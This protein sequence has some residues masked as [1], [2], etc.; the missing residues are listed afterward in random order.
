MLRSKAQGFRSIRG[1]NPKWTSTKVESLSSPIL[2]LHI[3]AQ[4]VHT[5]AKMC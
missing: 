2:A 5:E 3:I 1:G 4:S